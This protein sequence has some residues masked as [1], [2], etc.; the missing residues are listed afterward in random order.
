M[1]KKLTKHSDGLAL[2]IDGQLL[3][4]LGIDENT[5]LEVS[6]DGES[7]VVVP[8]RDE[9]RRKQIEEAL[10]AVNAQYASTLQRL[11]E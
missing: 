5:A 1:I 7:L 3:A 10:A 8:V 11:A 9:G 6:T 4:Q 2:V